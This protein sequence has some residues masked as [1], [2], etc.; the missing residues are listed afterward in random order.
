MGGE[1][2]EDGPILGRIVGGL[3]GLGA[4]SVAS[5]FHMGR[6]G[7]HDPKLSQRRRKKE[8]SY[9]ASPSPPLLVLPEFERVGLQRWPRD[10]TFINRRSH[11]SL[12]RPPPAWRRR[13]RLIDIGT[14]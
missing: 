10:L 11:G 8:A 12:H 5:R 4:V 2:V 7:N 9:K 14:V 13:R 1:G 3:L 6:A